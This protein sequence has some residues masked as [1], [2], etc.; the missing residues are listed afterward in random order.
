MSKNKKVIDVTDRV[1]RMEALE[2]RFGIS[3]DAL[4][5]RYEEHGS[6]EDTFRALS[7]NFDVV[8][9]TGSIDQDL[10]IVVSSYNYGQQLEGTTKSVNN[11]GRYFGLESCSVAVIDISGPPSRIRIFPKIW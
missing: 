9:S 10:A 2:E 1:E 4:Y 3:I 8:S 7:A 6:G 5:V 11:M